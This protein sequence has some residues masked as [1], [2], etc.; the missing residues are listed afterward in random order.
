MNDDAESLKTVISVA[1]SLA[2]DMRDICLSSSENIQLFFKF[3]LKLAIA[4]VICIALLVGCIMY[5]LYQAYNYDGYSS[6]PTTIENNNITGKDNK[7][8]VDK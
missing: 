5:A 2:N 1:N 8:G 7:I 6:N 4:F 3:T